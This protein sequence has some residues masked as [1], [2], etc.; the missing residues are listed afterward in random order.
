M[1]YRCHLLLY[2]NIFNIPI[3]P[4]LPSLLLSFFLSLSLSFPLLPSLSPSPSPSSS[5][6]LNAFPTHRYSAQR[7]FVVSSGNVI[8]AVTSRNQYPAEVPFFLFPSH[9]FSP[10]SSLGGD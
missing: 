3:P 7:R 9:L 5:I 10:L 6:H 2:G 8:G 4:F 1:G